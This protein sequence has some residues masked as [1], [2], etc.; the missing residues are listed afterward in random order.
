MNSFHFIVNPI[1]G[2]GNGSRALKQIKSH[3]VGKDIRY[4][5]S[6]TKYRG[7]A[8][9]LAASESKGFDNIISVGGDGTLNEI[10]N[11]IDL[12]S[13]INLG[14]IPV[15]SGNDFALNLHISKDIAEN[16][17]LIL[18]KEK[19]TKNFKIGLI[20]Y[21]EDGW[22][23]DNLVEHRFINSLGIGFD[24]FVAH[25]N[26]SNKVLSGIFSYIYAILKAVIHYQPINISAKIDNQLIEGKK[27]LIAIGNGKTSGG[28]FYLTPHA[29]IDSQTFE[30]CFIDFVK[31]FKLIRSLPMAIFN[32]IETVKEVTLKYFQHAEIEIENPYFIHTDGEIIS[33]KVIFARIKSLETNIKIIIKNNLCTQNK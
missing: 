33:T 5:I 14:V 20:Q 16:L 28:G 21:Q 22:S 11:G 4:K 2:K 6:E 3:L 25:L 23:N 19:S 8:R 9:E 30:I 17:N 29:E 7:H 10:I 13:G 18:N 15:G 26:Q 1:A 27:L 24:A 31:R 32:K 12:F